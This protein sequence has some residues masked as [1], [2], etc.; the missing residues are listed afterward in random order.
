[1]RRI[2]E[3]CWTD[4]HLQASTRFCRSMAHFICTSI[5]R[6]F[7]TIVLTSPNACSNRPAWRQLLA[8][9]SIRSM[10]ELSCACAMPDRMKIC[11]K[12]SKGAAPGS[13]DKRSG[14]VEQGPCTQPAMQN[15]SR[16]HESGAAT[17]TRGDLVLSS[18]CTHD[19]RRQLVDRQCRNHLRA[20]RAMSG[21]S[22]ARFD[23]SFG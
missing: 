20:E 13:R 15:G 18:F 5:H 7:R 23:G 9:I 1:M 4:Y 17:Q 2:A 19:S 11:A 8:S 14:L 21:A 22:R 3:S 10:A 6:A 12:L 16:D